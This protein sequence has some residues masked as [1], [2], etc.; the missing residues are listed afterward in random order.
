[1]QNIFVRCCSGHN[2]SVCRDTNCCKKPSQQQQQEAHFTL[3][4]FFAA[5]KQPQKLSQFSFQSN[6]LSKILVFLQKNQRIALMTQKVDCIEP[7]KV[8]ELVL[9]LLTYQH[10]PNLRNPLNQVHKI[11]SCKMCLRLQFYITVSQF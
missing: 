3:R 4:Y 11:A 8:T 2:P 9:F 6:F 5:E 10:K 7:C 1:M